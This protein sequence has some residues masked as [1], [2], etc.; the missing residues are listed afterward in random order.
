MK[1]ARSLIS[2]II[3]LAV[4]VLSGCEKEPKKKAPSPPKVTVAKPVVQDV[5]NYIYIT[6]YSEA[7]NSVEL[8]ARVEGFLESFSF[9]PGT[10]V[11]KGDLLFAID[12]KPLAAIVT[13]AKANLQI[14]QAESKLAEASLKR[15]ESAYKEKA[16]SELA[17]LEARAELS[18]SHA[19]V[20]GAEAALTSAQLDL[21]YTTIHA[22]VSGRISRPLVDA[23]NLVGSGGDKT[24]LAT[25]ANYDP[26]YVYFNLDER[27]LMR[28]KRHNRGKELNS[29]GK[30]PVFL[31][32]EGDEGYPY[33]GY[34][35][36]MENKVDLATGTIQMRA[37]F[38]NKDLFILPRLFAK[39]RIPYKKVSDALLVP[40]AALS[41]DQRGRYLLTVNSKNIVEY[42]PVT[43][44]ALVD[45]LRVIKKGLSADDRVVVKGIQRARPGAEVTPGEQEEKKHYAENTNAKTK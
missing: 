16:V 2:F 42:K 15:K 37:V 32:L 12:P 17:V 29:T 14:C 30:T 24:L 31:A 11:K 34:M 27:S 7:K 9:A 13:Q 5:T 1:I 35:D 44:G 23:G 20:K 3:I 36:Y 38:E 8:R 10:M 41:A 4:I 19:E 39:V 28:Y 22:P 33:E 25:I 43:I 18:K 6:G 21:S 40:D 45:G 26:I